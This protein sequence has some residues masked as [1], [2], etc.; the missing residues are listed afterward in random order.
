[1]PTARSLGTARCRAFRFEPCHGSRSIRA[2][3]LCRGRRTPFDRRVRPLHLT[4][5]LAAPPERY[6]PLCDQVIVTVIVIGG[7]PFIVTFAIHANAKRRRV[8]PLG[9]APA[10]GRTGGSA[11]GRHGAQGVSAT[12]IARV[13]RPHLR[14]GYSA[15]CRCKHESLPCS[16]NFGKL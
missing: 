7:T 4:H 6:A 3:T 1:M 2:A 15:V 12:P 16:Q 9:I 5:S 13:T 10:A 11:D 8:C 14:A